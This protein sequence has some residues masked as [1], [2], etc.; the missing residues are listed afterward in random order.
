MFRK[1]LIF[2][3]LALAFLICGNSQAAEL[4]I[5]SIDTQKVFY[6]YNKRKD[7]QKSLEEKDK[8]LRAEVE[9][10]TQEIRKLR[11]EIDLL[12]D[13]A[14]A[15]KE[16]ELREKIKQFDEFGNQKREEFIREKDEMYKE[17]RDDIL[18]V[19]EE[20][21]KQNGYDLVFDKTVFIYSI[22]KYDVTDP[23]LK[24]LNK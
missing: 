1:I 13:K 10:K 17:I 23:I 5:G 2:I 7:F 14:K 12:S 4:K 15:K 11:D 18:K 6:E 8:K 3:S 19:S 21:A 20:Y 9:K 24:A 22:D 16:P